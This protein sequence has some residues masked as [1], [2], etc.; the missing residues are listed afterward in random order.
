MGKLK[1]TKLFYTSDLH[2]S[3]VCFKKF[4]NAGKLYG[5]DALIIGGD[6]TGK[7]VVPIVQTSADTYEIKEYLGGSILQGK[8]KLNDARKAIEDAGYYSYVCSPDEYSELKNNNAKLDALFEQLELEKIKEWLTLAGNRLKGTNSK[9]YIMAGN[10]DSQVIVESL[11]SGQSEHV[12]HCESKVVLIDGTYEMISCGY[13]NVTPWRC[14]R[15][16]EEYDLLRI[17]DE[18][19][20]KVGKMETAIFNLHV[21]PVSSGIDVAPAV[22]YT[23]WKPITHGGEPRMIPVGSTAVR[24]AIDTYQ[25]LVSL[26]GH[27][28]ESKGIYKLGRTLCINPGSEYQEGIL[29]GV[30]V[31]LSGTKVEF[32]FTSG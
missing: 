22:D 24:T 32:A 18:T 10:D 17:I 3:T 20:S 25:P 30:I 12:I 5:A 15:D 13:S 7:A 2:A 19:A 1:T 23:T 27:V 9:L 29:R 8:E 31:T 28:H 14:P 11:E 21:P 26:H 16:V 6:L 4:I